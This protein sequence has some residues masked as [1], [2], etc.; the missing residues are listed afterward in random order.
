MIVVAPYQTAIN[1]KYAGKL[2]ISVAWHIVSYAYLKRRL[3]HIVE[4]LR[5]LRAKPRKKQNLIL[6]VFIL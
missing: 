2:G 3:Q 1:A 6:Y 5:T 4:N